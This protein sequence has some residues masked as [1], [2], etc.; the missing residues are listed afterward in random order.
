[1]SAPADL[2]GTLDERTRQLA[3]VPESDQTAEWLRRQLKG[4]LEA[5]AE[6]QTALD[7][8]REGRDDF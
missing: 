1:M 4:A 7:V 2:R 8:D 6:D 5:W 3:S